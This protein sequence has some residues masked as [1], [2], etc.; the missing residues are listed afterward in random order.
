MSVFGSDES[1]A[2]DL[3]IS[4]QKLSIAGLVPLAGEVV[5]RSLEGSWVFVEVKVQAFFSAELPEE[6]VTPVTILPSI[7]MKAGLVPAT[8][9]A[10][11]QPTPGVME[12][13]ACGLLVSGTLI[14][15]TSAP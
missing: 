10:S 6:S 3:F 12:I 7:L 8:C 2:N 1:P 9:L 4:K 15:R 5:L 14:K 11:I 13:L